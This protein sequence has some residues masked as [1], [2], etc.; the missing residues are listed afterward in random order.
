MALQTV[1]SGAG[2][3]RT[4]AGRAEVSPGRLAGSRARGIA[5]EA[6]G[7]SC[8][9]VEQPQRRTSVF[10]DDGRFW[11]T[12]Q[13]CRA[14]EGFPERADDVNDWPFEWWKRA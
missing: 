10:D 5:G 9:V 12:L 1:T 7:Y 4:S 6:L 14:V 13:G 8:R 2:S 11:S 3:G